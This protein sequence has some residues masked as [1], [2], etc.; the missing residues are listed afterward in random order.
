MVWAKQH[1]IDSKIFLIDNAST[2]ETGAEAI[3]MVSPL[4]TYRHNTERWGFQKSVN[5]GV[6]DGFEN[7]YDLVLILNNDV[8]LHPE[9]IWRIAERFSKDGVGL[10]SCMDV[11]GEM[12]QAGINPL[13][14][15]R[16][17]SKEKETVDESPNPNFSAFAVNK[18]CWDTV[19]EF[20][21]VFAPAY[22]EDNDYHYRMK[23]AE[24]PAITYPPAMFYH[25]GSRTQN[26]ANENGKPLV[27]S[28]MF[29][30]TRAF[31]V[32]KWGGLPGAEKWTMPYGDP[33]L[34][35]TDVKQTP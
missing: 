34:L 3:K 12:T 4:F 19:G 11:R 21:E 6:N 25:F 15:T 10:V 7:G 5:L 33:M 31:Y 13:G 22:F 29:E 32:K 20:D 8:I 30:N 28:P 16:I 2:D 18:E 27:P 17:L 1:D 23:I 24:I 26:E 14:I 35:I 9:A